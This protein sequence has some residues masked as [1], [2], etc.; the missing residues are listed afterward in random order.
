MI[1]LA[2][3]R[4]ENDLF[5]MCILKSEGEALDEKFKNILFKIYL[6]MNKN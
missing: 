6:L 2:K 1:S 3:K 5:G 4:E